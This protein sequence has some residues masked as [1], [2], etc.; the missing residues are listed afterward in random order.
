MARISLIMDF[1]PPEVLR[2]LNLV[3]GIDGRQFAADPS[4]PGVYESGVVYRREEDETFA[5]WK[6]T[7]LQGWED[8]DSLAP[9]RAGELVARGYRALRLGDDGY[10]HAQRNRPASIEAWCFLTTRSDPKEKGKLYHVEVNY[11]IG[12]RIYHDDPSARLGM[13]GEAIDPL[14]EQLWE[15]RGVSPG[16]PVMVGGVRFQRLVR[17]G[18]GE[19]RTG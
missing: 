18:R 6:N 11:H 4:L 19:W 9:A 15:E 8:C 16:Q 13:Y 5:D 2:L 17:R 14:V 3:A 1:S 7:L 10:E 12:G